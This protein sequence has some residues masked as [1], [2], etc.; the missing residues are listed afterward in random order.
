MNKIFTVPIYNAT[1]WLIVAKDISKARKKMEFA[2][3]PAPQEDYDALCCYNG[4]RYGLFFTPESS[5]DVDTIAHEI[6]HL[7][8]RILDWAGTNF[9]KAHHEHAALLN[10]YLTKLVNKELNKFHNP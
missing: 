10:G 2:F 1:L 8:H 7:T 3:G 4:Y 9:D 6:F 5:Q